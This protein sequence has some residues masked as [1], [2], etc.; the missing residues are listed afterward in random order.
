MTLLGVEY[1]NDY[2]NF[3]IKFQTYIFEILRTTSSDLCLRTQLAMS[4]SL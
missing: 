3:K 1:T 4:I 2:G